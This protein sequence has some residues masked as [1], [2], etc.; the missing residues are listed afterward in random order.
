MHDSRAAWNAQRRGFTL[1]ELLVVVAVVAVLIGILLPVLGKAREMARLAQ[2]QSNLRQISQGAISYATE[3]DD[4]WPFV[5]WQVTHNPSYPEYDQYRFV[6]YNYGGKSTDSFWDMR[7]GKSLIRERP[8]N[9][10]LFPDLELRDPVGKRMELPLFKCPSDIGTYQRS[11]WTGNPNLDYTVSSYDDVGTSYHSN[12]KWW[13]RDRAGASNEN[14]ERRWR[15]LQKALKRAWLRQPA[16]FVWNHDQTMDYLLYHADSRLGD[17][18]EINRS[19][20]AFMDGHV[21]YIE[22][23]P[24]VFNTVKYHTVLDGEE[25]VQ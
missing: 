25:Y 2:C 10:Y 7:P 12:I 14:H 15:R 5:P 22:V 16:R 11:F 24:Y 18:G 21:G 4:F 3:H 9:R 17:H 20:M 23:I 8:L 13:Y 19:A 6:S 1:I